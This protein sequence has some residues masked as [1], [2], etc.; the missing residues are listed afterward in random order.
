MLQYHLGADIDLRT[1]LSSLTFVQPLRGRQWGA[2]MLFYSVICT[3][4]K[5][6]I[7]QLMIFYT[8]DVSAKT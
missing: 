7:Q 2:I 1:D 3:E 6:L 5:N 8:N 4:S